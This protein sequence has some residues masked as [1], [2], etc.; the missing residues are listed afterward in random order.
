MA[1]L[2]DLLRHWFTP[3]S[4]NNYRARLLHNTSLILTIGFIIGASALIRLIEVTPLNILGFSSTVTIDEVVV[5]TNRQRIVA[6][7]KP[8]QYSEVLSDAA[9]RKA[10][11]M[12]AENYWAHNAPSGKS[13]WTWFNEAG[14]KYTHAGENLAKDFGNTDNMIAA[15]MDSPTH[16]DNIISDKYQEI[17]VA[18]VPGTLVGKETVLVVQLF[19]STS[20]AIGSVTDTTEPT[21]TESQLAVKGQI[22]AAQSELAPISFGTYN[23]FNVKKILGISVATLFLISLFMDLVIAEN[24]SLSRRVGKNWGHIVVINVILLLVT[25]AHAGSIL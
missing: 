11:N 22:A 2:I 18:V 16:R 3:G 24:N 14:Y 12:F 20:Q 8:L 21:T 7:L 13:P 1:S 23:N 4:T 15:W 19:G 17:G 25:I 10:A 6:G 9:R 5:A